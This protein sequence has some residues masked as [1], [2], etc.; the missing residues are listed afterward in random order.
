MRNISRIGKFYTKSAIFSR[1][2][3]QRSAE[4]CCRYNYKSENA[5]PL[6]G[7]MDWVQLEERIRFR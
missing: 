4:V 5:I 2:G 6:A 1:R 7:T 3:S